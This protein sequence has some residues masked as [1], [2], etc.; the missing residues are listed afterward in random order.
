M[1]RL[2]IL[3]AAP[4]DLPA[5]AECEVRLADPVGAGRRLRR[6][7]S[8]RRG[9]ERLPR[10]AHNRLH[11]LRAHRGR[12]TRRRGHSRLEDVRRLLHRIPQRVHTNQVMPVPDRLNTQRNIPCMLLA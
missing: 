11:E 6:V 3:A 1:L 12:A 4:A 7:R 8:G 9:D 2:A 5:G 10:R